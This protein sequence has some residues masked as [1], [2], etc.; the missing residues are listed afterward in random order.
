MVG[1]FI[2]QQDVR[3]GQQQLHKSEPCTLTA[4]E[5]TDPPPQVILT[6]AKACD[7]V[8]HLALPLIAPG[9]FKRFL[10]AG[11]ERHAFFIRMLCH[12]H[13]RLIQLLLQLPHTG[14]YGFQLLLD[15]G[16]LIPKGRL[17]QIADP[18]IVLFMDRTTVKLFCCA[19]TFSS[20][21]L[22]QPLRPT[23]AIFSL[24][25]ISN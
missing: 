3:L 7:D 18:H 8:H 16:V 22:P 9:L 20:V 24:F 25:L 23:T 4:A 14:K 5:F 19:M 11:I 2:Q 15:G 13:R 10:N 6:K 1:R 21:V 17:C 12:R